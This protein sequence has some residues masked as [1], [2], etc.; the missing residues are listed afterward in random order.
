MPTI[1]LTPT[2]CTSGSGWKNLSWYGNT[3]QSDLRQLIFTYPN[4]ADLGG[5]GVNITSITLSGYVRNSS[6]ASK[7]L[8]YGCKTGASAQPSQWAQQSGTNILDSAFTAVN[9]SNGGYLYSRI[10][11]GLTGAT[12]QMF[13]ANMTSQFASG[14]SFYLGVVQPDRSKSIQVDPTL[15]NWTVTVVYEQLGNLP[16]IDFTNVPLGNYITTTINRVVEGST[17]TLTYKIGENVLETRDIG[18]ATTD[19]FVVPESAGQYFPNTQM[20]TLVVSAETFVGNMS[21]GVVNASTTVSIPG[22]A[23]P[24]VSTTVTRTWVD[25]VDEAA[26]I[27]AYVQSKT[28]VE[29]TFQ[30]T[31]KYGATMASYQQDIGGVVLTREGNGVIPFSPITA[32]GSDG[33]VPYIYIATDSRGL[34]YTDDG[35]QSVQPWEAPKITKFSVSRVNVDNELAIDGTY[36]RATVEASCSS[37]QVGGVEKNKQ[38]YYVKFREIGATAW[39]NAD[40]VSSNSIAVNDSALLM[41]NGEAIDT[42]NDMAGYEF[43]L[44]LYDI[45]ETV[46]AVDNVPTKETFLDINETNGSMGFGGEATGTGDT[47]EYDFYGPVHFHAGAP[48]AMVYSTEETNTGSTWIDNKEIF[49]KMIAFNAPSQKNAS[50]QVTYDFSNIDTAWIDTSATFFIANDTTTTVNHV[51]YVSSDGARLFMVQLR[52]ERNQIL[53]VTN[54]GGTAYIRLMYTKHT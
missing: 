48:G 18:T 44:V 2:A 27:D 30:G 11:R 13:A 32:V 41:S 25:G 54:F 34:T 43:Q 16:S 6:S 22:D 36:I 53:V 7:R 45:Y 15:N 10:S 12:L 23:G 1:T 47:P 38:A 24:T 14:G 46:N 4:N 51:G 5:A 21:Y 33:I 40:L 39:T 17:T 8:Q 35:S 50:T 31:P 20:T 28:G 9:G 19:V 26:K 29:F 37:L 49:V 3:S 42:F 52:P